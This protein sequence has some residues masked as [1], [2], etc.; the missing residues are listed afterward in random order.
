MS[1]QPA[2]LA[3]NLHVPFLLL[4]HQVLIHPSCTAT[5]R[6]PSKDKLIHKLILQKI[7]TPVVIIMQGINMRK[8]KSHVFLHKNIHSMVQ[9]GW[10]FTSKQHMNKSTNGILL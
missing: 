4:H 6:R 10:H 5:E 8:R 1:F 2:K 3:C 7:A 9:K